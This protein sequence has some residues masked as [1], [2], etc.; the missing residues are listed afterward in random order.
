MMYEFH[1]FEELSFEKILFSEH[2]EVHL[3]PTAFNP[4]YFTEVFIN[5]QPIAQVGYGFLL[6]YHRETRDIDTFDTVD[7]FIQLH[8]VVVQ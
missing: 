2:S 4:L 7:I 6:K 1:R 8:R 3:F 5:K